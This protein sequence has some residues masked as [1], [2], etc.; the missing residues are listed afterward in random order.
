M[1]NYK[2]VTKDKS[3]AKT[4]LEEFKTS[5]RAKHNAEKLIKNGIFDNHLIYSMHV[6]ETYSKHYEVDKVNYFNPALQKTK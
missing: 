1:S 3:G 2:L 4:V 6:V 5:A